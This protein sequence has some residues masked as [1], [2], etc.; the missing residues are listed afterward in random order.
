MD[1][2]EFKKQFGE[3]AKAS[4]FDRAF[5][6]WFKESNETIIVLELQ[7]SNFGNYYQ[8]NIKVFIQG[9]FWRGLH[10]K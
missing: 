5:G 8:L 1:N 6:G 9:F 3:I 4:R 2:T 7:K 10:E